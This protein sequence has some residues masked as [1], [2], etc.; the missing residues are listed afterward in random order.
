MVSEIAP[1]GVDPKVMAKGKA[2]CRA[3]AVTARAGR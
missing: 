1:G 3:K 2:R